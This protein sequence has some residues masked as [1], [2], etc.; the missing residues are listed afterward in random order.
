MEDNT[1]VEN[2]YKKVLKSSEVTFTCNSYDFQQWYYV[3]HSIRKNLI[4]PSYSPTPAEYLG[5]NKTLKIDVK[6]MKNDGYYYCY[7]RYENSEDKFI[8]EARVIVFGK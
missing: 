4:I 5:P 2:P 7:G 8:A 1:E 6:D 3:E